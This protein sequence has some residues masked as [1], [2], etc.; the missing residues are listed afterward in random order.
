[1]VDVVVLDVLGE[2]CLEVTAAEDDHPVE[3]LAP[4]GADDALADG[5]GTRCLDRALDDPGALCGED[6]VEGSRE[7][8]VAI[9][10]EELESVRL[11]GEVHREIA[12]LLGHPI[13][14]RRGGH[15]GDPHETRVVV[16]EL[17]GFDGLA[18]AASGK[19]PLAIGLAGA[20]EMTPVVRE[21]LQELRPEQ[22]RGERS[23]GA[24]TRLDTV[25]GSVSL[26]CQAQAALE[27]PREG[28]RWPR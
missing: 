11:V 26:A 16:G 15:A 3:A 7:L 4:D 24:T 18:S 2:D 13:G 8:G 10:D 12:G 22:G 17:L 5:V 9:A 27:I 25:D 20:V 23:G 19:E 21:P 28:G 6:G 14:Y 1:M